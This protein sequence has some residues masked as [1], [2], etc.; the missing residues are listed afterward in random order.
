VIAV[1]QLAI[2]LGAPLGRAAWGGA[3]VRLP[4][5]LRVASAVAAVIWMV[6]ALLVLDRA[7]TPLI[8]LPDP[9]SNGWGPLAIVLAW[10]WRSA[11]AA[12]IM[13]SRREVRWLRVIDFFSN[14]SCDS[15]YTSSRRL[16]R[17]Q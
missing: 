15:S 16:W 3:H 14:R 7:G 11:D 10:A 9:V 17:S 4:P 6:A 8:D 13:E 1:F 2:A 12:A 5:N